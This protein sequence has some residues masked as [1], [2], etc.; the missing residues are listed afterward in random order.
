MDNKQEVHAGQAVYSKKTLKIYD[1]WVLGFS[2]HFLWKCPTQRIGHQF[3][4]LIS[5]NHLDVGVGTGYYFKKYL[6]HNKRR[7]ALVD[8]NAN[9]L[10][11]ASDIIKIQNP[12]TFCRNIL[13]PL[14]LQTQKF[15]SV[16][17]NYLLHCLPGDM[18]SKSVV[19]KHLKEEMNT[20]GVLFGS[21]ILGEGTEQN[22]GAKKLMAIYNKKGIFTNSQ[23]NLAV[24]TE[25]LNQEFVDVNIQ[26][27]GCVAVFSA[28]KA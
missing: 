24:L 15:D 9:S 6:P 19:F 18:K 7:V 12:E 27:I 22:L 13:E 28:R 23:D 21:T 3:Q 16:S 8:M 17:I 1:F 2:N 5:D 11:A 25:A 4:T 26:M 20:N 10:A 14:S